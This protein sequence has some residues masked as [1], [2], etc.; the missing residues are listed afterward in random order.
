ML[1]K[2]ISN[3]TK[4]TLTI[5][6]SLFLLL[7][8]SR[9]A[10]AQSC[11]GTGCNGQSPSTAGC[12]ADAEWKTA[13]PFTYNGVQGYVQL[14][15]SEAC[16]AAFTRVSTA[17]NVVPPATKIQTYFSR[18]SSCTI[19]SPIFASQSIAFSM[20][21]LNPPYSFN[22][23]ANTDFTYH[24]DGNLYYDTRSDLFWTPGARFYTTNTAFQYFPGI[25]SKL[26]QLGGDCP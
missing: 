25:T 14:M 21:S 10:S 4:L 12:L 1:N 15:W 24:V 8:N 11:Y 3:F 17:S 22:Q 18:I 6:I 7:V 19:C 5:S 9:S 13:K 20:Y 23:V 26:C 2:N 16:K